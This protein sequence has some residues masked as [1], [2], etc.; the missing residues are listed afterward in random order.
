M[1]LRD[2]L[3]L[4]D[5]ILPVVIYYD[6]DEYGPYRK[7]VVPSRWLDEKV[8]QVFVDDREDIGIDVT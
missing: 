6:G 5:T 4:L 8:S 7:D 2:F 1:K 3:K